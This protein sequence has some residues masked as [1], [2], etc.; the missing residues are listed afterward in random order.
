M[1]VENKEVLDGSKKRQDC[2]T[3]S[4]ETSRLH[5]SKP[6]VLESRTGNPVSREP[7]V[8]R[9]KA[10]PAKRSEKGYGDE[11]VLPPG[12]IHCLVARPKFI[13]RN[14]QI[15]PRG[16]KN[17]SKG[18]LRLSTPNG[19]ADSTAFGLFFDIAV[20]IIFFFHN[21]KR[22]QSRIRIHVNT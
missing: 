7:F 13:F 6:E 5:T 3:Q 4:L 20:A 22:D 15:E 17:L 16:V 11:N 18:K 21:E 9:A 10:P 2:P 12:C 14:Q 19:L 1:A 8:S